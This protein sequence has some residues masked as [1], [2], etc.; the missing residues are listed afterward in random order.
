MGTELRRLKPETINRALLNLR[1]HI[2]RDGG[3]GLRHVN[4][5]L[6]LQGCALEPVPKKA[7]RHFRRGELMRAIRAE[8]RKGPLTAWQLAERI[9]PMREGLSLQRAHATVHR[10]LTPM[11]ARG[12]VRNDS[13]VW[14]LADGAAGRG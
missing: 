11:R 13:G 6:R 10:A 3:E 12:V 7:Q 8:L 4:A 14:S 2:I 5:L 9:A 1:A